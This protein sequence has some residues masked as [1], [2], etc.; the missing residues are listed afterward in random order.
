MERDFNKGGKPRTEREDE[1][2]RLKSIAQVDNGKR[3]QQGRNSGGTRILGE[4]SVGKGVVPTYKQCSS[5]ETYSTDSKNGLRSHPTNIPSPLSLLLVLT[6]VIHAQN[7]INTREHSHFVTPL[8][9]PCGRLCASPL[10]VPLRLALLA[11]PLWPTLGITVLCLHSTA[12][13]FAHRSRSPALC[14]HFPCSQLCA[15]P[16]STC[17]P[18]RPTS[19]SALAFPCA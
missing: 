1:N 12:P 10:T 16:R 6:N 5:C 3:L 15:L 17:I 13:D 2:K 8:N 14:S 18:L 4:T 7:S 19:H 9:F 11:L